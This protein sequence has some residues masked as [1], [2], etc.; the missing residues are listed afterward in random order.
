MID[1]KSHSENRGWIEGILRLIPGFRGYLEKDYRQESDFLAR[2]YM[3]DR[4]QDA[5]RDLDRFMVA[6]IDAGQ[7]DA[8]TACERLKTQIDTLVN[9]LRGAVRG[10]SGFFDFVKV[11]ES[12]LE[13]VY[14]HDMTMIQGVDSFADS[15][16]QLAAKPDASSQGLGDLSKQLSDL[17]NR[18][19][20]RADMLVGLA[21]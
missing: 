10:Y 20:Q 1:P 11:N 9:K 3:A 4:L 5:K 15:M 21:E 8:M 17:E 18:F 6:L 19:D 12:L 13:K 7:L 2:K 16:A 14:E